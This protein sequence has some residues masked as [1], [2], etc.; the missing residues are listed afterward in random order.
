MTKQIVFLVLPSMHLMDLA[1]PDQVFFEAQGFGADLVIRYCSLGVEVRTTAGLPIGSVPGF[2]S[3]VLQE[4][5]HLIVPG[6][7]VEYLHSPS[8]G[9]QSGLFA[10]LAD[11]HRRGAVLSS[12]CSGAFVLARAG[13]LDGRAC[14]THWKRTSELQQRYPRLRVVENVLF[15]HDAGIYTSAGIA[16]GIDLALHLV[17]QI[18]GAAFSHKVARELVIFARRQGE[19]SQHSI[20]LSY[21]NHIHAGI[22]EVQDW[23]QENLDKKAKLRDLARIA[24]MSERTLTRSFRK[25]TGVSV[26]QYVTLL[27][28]ARIAE[29]EKNPDLSRR[30]V[31]ELCGLQSERQ[32]SRLLASTRAG[33]DPRAERRSQA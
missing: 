7:D 19:D 20:Y 13:L 18:Y 32:V 11:A 17:E 25:E 10:W 24:H 27:R 31:A 14:T 28:K 2:Q 1:G 8:F 6:A 29:L 5:D 21:R 16:S 9:R 26:K 33:R 12:I 23:L 3:V 30:Q 4:G 15:T 22:H